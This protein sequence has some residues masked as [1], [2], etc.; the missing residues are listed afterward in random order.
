MFPKLFQKI[1]NSKEN[2]YRQKTAKIS[3]DFNDFIKKYG[4][5]HVITS[6]YNLTAKRISEHINSTIKNILQIYKGKK[7]RQII[8]KIDVNLNIVAI[9]Y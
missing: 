5:Q 3:S 4:I 7:L 8:Q 2:T 1:F 9:R 6:P